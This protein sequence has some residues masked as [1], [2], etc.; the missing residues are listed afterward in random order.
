[1]DPYQPSN[2]D[3]LDELTVW[4]F[5]FGMFYQQIK[6]QQRAIR[7]NSILSGDDRLTDFLYGHWERIFNRTC[8]TRECFVSFSTIMEGTGKLL[9]SRSVSVEEQIMIFLFV[10]GHGASDHNSQETWQRSGSTILKYFGLV[11]KQSLI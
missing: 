9:P 6:K 7:Y 4:W 5:F 2:N 1:M 10:V 8:M 11:W 3:Y